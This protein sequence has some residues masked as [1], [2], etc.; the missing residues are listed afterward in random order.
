MSSSVHRPRDLSKLSRLARLCGSLPVA[1]VLLAAAGCSSSA[2]D[3]VAVPTPS[4][5]VATVCRTLHNALPEKV[6]GLARHATHPASDLTAAWGDPAIVLRCGVPT[7]DVLN[8]G[9][10]HYNPTA[11]AA[12]I[13][14][15][16]W[17]PEKQS[18][19]SVRCTTTLRKAFVEVTIPS[20]YTG[21][22]GDISAL[23]DLADAVKK[24]DPAGL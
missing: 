23:T 22:Y 1:A 24:S 3:T 14:G 17:L 18:D 4:T 16:D 8:P 11:D 9:S 5:A 6:N 20:K 19:G 10:A 2:T 7:P 21:P 15:V 12:S 13:N